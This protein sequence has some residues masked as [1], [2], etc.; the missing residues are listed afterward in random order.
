MIYILHWK[1]PKSVLVPYTVLTFPGPIPI[2]IARE[3][4]II[5]KKNSILQVF[6]GGT[7]ATRHTHYQTNGRPIPN[8]IIPESLTQNNVRYFALGMALGSSL[9]G[10]I[11]VA[12]WNFTFPSKVELVL[13][14]VA[15]IYCT[16]FF[17]LFFGLFALLNRFEWFHIQ[18][19]KL[20]SSLYVLARVFMILEMFRTLCFLTPDA[21]TSTWAT[22]I[23]HLA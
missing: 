12:A 22:N 20:V 18:M 9:F 16:V 5:N 3:E 23:P 6:F 4:S 7:E 13:W 14:R 2:E 17:S 8:D 1:K 11:H 21:Y 19:N 10:V 15:S